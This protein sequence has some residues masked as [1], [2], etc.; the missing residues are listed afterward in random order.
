MN[1]VR[2]HIK[3]NSHQRG[4]KPSW[5]TCVLDTMDA[6]ISRSWLTLDASNPLGGW[7]SIDD[8]GTR[9]TAQSAGLVAWRHR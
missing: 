7:L 9:N 1:V 2:I 4:V 3:I 6:T 8:R 5:A